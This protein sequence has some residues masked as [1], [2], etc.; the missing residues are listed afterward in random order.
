MKYISSLQKRVTHFPTCIESGESDN[1]LL[2]KPSGM[3]MWKENGVSGKAQ[4]TNGE[5]GMTNAIRWIYGD[6][7]RMPYVAPQAWL[8]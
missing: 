6:V 4:S 5:L 7:L 3:E 8:L 2:E 1:E